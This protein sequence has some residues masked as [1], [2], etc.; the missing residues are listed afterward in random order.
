MKKY[1]FNGSIF[2][3]SSM[4]TKLKYFGKTHESVLSV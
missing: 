3:D 2:R 1:I 4:D